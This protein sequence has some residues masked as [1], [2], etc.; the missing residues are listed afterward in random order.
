M[1]RVSVLI[2][3]YN[4]IQ[5]IDRC[6]KSVLCQ[7]EHE[8]Q[9]VFVDDGSH[10]NSLHEALKYHAL[11]AEK[12]HE[13]IVLSQQNGGAASAIH[14][15]LSKA[16][17][18][19]LVLLDVDDEFLPD[20]C[21]MQADYLDSHSDCGIVLTDGNVVS[22]KSGEFLYSLRCKDVIADH[23][24]IIS[25][26]MKG[27]I[28]NIPGAYMVRHSLIKDF[29]AHHKFICDQ[30]GQNLQIMMPAAHK[31]FAGY[32][33]LPLFN[34]YRP[35]QSHSNP[36]SFEKE[37]F[38]LE[39]YL[40][41]RLNMANEMGLDNKDYIKSAKCAFLNS[42]LYVCSKYRRKDEF[43]IYAAKLREFRNLTLSEKLDESV[44]NRRPSQFYYRV[45]RFL[46]DKLS[47]GYE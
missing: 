29:Y 7:T 39:G 10:D 47:I 45:I 31:H 24:D 3:C 11:F 46:A 8:M 43:N 9:V 36:G 20:S 34:Y 27:D 33:D 5:Y 42:A 6:F 44:L 18:K 40:G 21:K 4:G 13:L 2:P 38:N 23:I 41:M 32:I 25:G 35:E 17:S 16:S 28:K 30:F 22:Q 26:L 15:A 1:R 12:G 14:R 19:Y 37:I